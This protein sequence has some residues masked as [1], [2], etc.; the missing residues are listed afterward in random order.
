[1]VREGKAYRRKISLGHESAYIVEV[2]EGV[3]KGEDVVVRGHHQ[4]NDG[5]RITV[6]KREEVKK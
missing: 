5:D 2:S 4:L 6:V 3:E 1:V